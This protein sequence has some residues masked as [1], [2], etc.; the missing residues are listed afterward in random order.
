MITTLTVRRFRRLI[1]GPRRNPLAS[2]PA[3]TGPAASARRGVRAGGTIATVHP[4]A[5]G[6]DRVHGGSCDL[7]RWPASL[8]E[9]QLAG[10]WLDTGDP[11][12]RDDLYAVC[13]SEDRAAAIALEVRAERRRHAESEAMLLRV[14]GPRPGGAR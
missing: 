5:R 6:D 4:A 11:A 7:T 8:A 2:Q 3:A 1:A 10:E 13:G 9:E 14:F 12:T